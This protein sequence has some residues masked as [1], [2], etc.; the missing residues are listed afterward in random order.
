MPDALLPATGPPAVDLGSTVVVTIADRTS[1]TAGDHR[2]LVGLIARLTG[3]A[4]TA[5]SLTQLCPQCGATDHG[6]LRATLAGAADDSP[7]YVSLARAGGLLAVAVT[8]AGPVGIDL[9]SVADLARSPVAGVMLSAAEAAGWAALGRQPTPTE[10]AVVWTSKEAVLKAAGVGLRVDPRD[11]TV[12]AD[13]ATGILGARR[14]AAWPL[15]PFDPDTLWLLPVA[16]PGGM[17]ATVAVVSAGPRPALHS[18]GR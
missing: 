18:V 12:V 14:L 16:A 17:V 2:V 10:L 1:T 15:S 8:G 6:A 9:E 7:V 5:V 11:L 4:D 13:A 3:V